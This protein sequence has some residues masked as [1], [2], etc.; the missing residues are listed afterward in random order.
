VRFANDS[1]DRCYEIPGGCKR[2]IKAWLNSE[3]EE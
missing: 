1:K 3:V 2:G